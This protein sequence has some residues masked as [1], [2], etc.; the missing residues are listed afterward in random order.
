[1]HRER[2]KVETSELARDVRGGNDEEDDLLQ[3]LES[4]SIQLSQIQSFQLQLKVRDHL[5]YCSSISL[6]R[7]NRCLLKYAKRCQVNNLNEHPLMIV[8][9]VKKRNE[10]S[11]SVSLRF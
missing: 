7:F 9:I 5:N 8:T 3:T 1:M 6:R 4:I 11:C 10:T 2:L